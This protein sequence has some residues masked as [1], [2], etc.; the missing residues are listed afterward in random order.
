MLETELRYRIPMRILLYGTEGV[1]VVE[2]G[3]GELLPL[4]F[5]SF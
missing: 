3:V 5:D 4:R 2:G 1:Y